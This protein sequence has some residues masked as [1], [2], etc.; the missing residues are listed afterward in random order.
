MKR[1]NRPYVG[2]LLC[3]YLASTTNSRNEEIQGRTR[4]RVWKIHIF[5]WRLIFYTRKS[6]DVFNLCRLKNDD[7]VVPFFLEHY[8]FGTRTRVYYWKKEVINMNK[9]I[10]EFGRENSGWDLKEKYGDNGMTALAHCR[11]NLKKKKINKNT[12]HMY[13]LN[14][15]IDVYRRECENE[16]AMHKCERQIGIVKSEREE[17]KRERER[18]ICTQVI[19]IILWWEP[20]RSTKKNWENYSLIKKIKIKR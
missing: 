15:P 20:Q 16:W 17:R 12:I 4:V 9:K 14:L 10:R 5:R 2:Y 6:R 1:R 11:P 13:Y 7:R 8:N 3:W 18:D 19:E